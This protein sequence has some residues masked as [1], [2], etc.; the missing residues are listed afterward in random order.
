MREIDAAKITDEVARLCMEAN[1]DLGKDVEDAIRDSLKREESTVGKEILNQL[2]ENARIA[3]EERLP[4][5]QDTGLAVIFIEMGQEVHIKGGTLEEAVNEGVRRGYTE[6]YLRKSVL[7]DPLKRVNTGDNTP[8]VI[9]L[10]LVAGEDFRMWVAPKGG[11]SEN[12]SKTTMLKPADGVEGVKNFVVESVRVASANPCPPTIVGVGIGGSFEQCALNAKKAL[13]RKVGTRNPDPFYADL[14]EEILAL[15][16]ETGVGPQGLGGR[17][18][19]LDVFIEAA[20]CHIASLPVAVN[21]NCHA[22]RHKYVE[23]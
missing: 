18:T 5:C 14:E 6:G 19:S 10:R 12:M 3:R 16:N 21:M 22:A 1:F 7:G 15:V 8:A 11:G 2:L 13:L 17:V 9:H 20:P 4:I 23:L